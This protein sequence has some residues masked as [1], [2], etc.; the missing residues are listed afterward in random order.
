MNISNF[1]SIANLN[2]RTVRVSGQ[3]PRRPGG[4][5]NL[6]EFTVKN[7]DLLK[8]K[9]A[10][11]VREWVFGALRAIVAGS[12]TPI[13]SELPPTDRG[14]LRGRGTG[15]PSSLRKTST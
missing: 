1:P 12:T 6:G 3:K 4:C 8:R 13:P 15:P 7:R 10:E 11:M 9:G 14:C 5:I 2:T